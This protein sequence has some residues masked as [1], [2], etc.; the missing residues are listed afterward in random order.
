MSGP[1]EAPATAPEGLRMTETSPPGLSLR[2][3]TALSPELVLRA[4]GPCDAGVLAALVRDAFSDH[5]GLVDPP[6][7]AA[8]ETSARIEAHL[9][10]GGRALMIVARDDPAAPLA[11]CLFHDIG[12]GFHIARL[13]VSRK[14]RRRGLALALLGAV[15]A[16]ARKE[17][18]GRLVLQTRLALVSNRALFARAGYR[19]VSFHAHPGFDAPTFVELEKSLRD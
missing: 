3:D 14:A 18:L 15:E 6:P 1:R 4:G 7:S 5:V 9:E 2:G 11:A 8:R 19:E 16:R 10:S 13:A 17:G 12:D